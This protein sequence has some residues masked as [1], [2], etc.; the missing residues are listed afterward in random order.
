M[1]Q[2]KKWKLGLLIFEEQ[3]RSIF[4]FLVLQNMFYSL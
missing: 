3:N 1:I 2:K 4:R